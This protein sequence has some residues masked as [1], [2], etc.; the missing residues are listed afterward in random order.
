[1]ILHSERFAGQIS[2]SVRERAFHYSFDCGII[3][4]G[5]GKRLCV[6]YLNVH[7]H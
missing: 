2:I 3:V 4:K 5:L 7:S 1:M 6:L